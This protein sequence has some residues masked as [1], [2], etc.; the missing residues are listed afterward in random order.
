MTIQT[1]AAYYASEGGNYTRIMDTFHY[2]NSLTK[3]LDDF[4]GEFDQEVLNEIVLWKINRYAQVDADTI[5][6]I[7]TISRTGSDLDSPLTKD[8]LLRLI[9]THGVRLP[10]ASTILR[11]R[12]PC[13]YQIID[14]RAYRLLYGYTYPNTTRKDKNIDI[15]MK[16]LTDLRRASAE[17][18]IPF[19][20]MDRYLYQLDKIINSKH[21]LR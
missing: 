4:D 5:S 9:S 3:K 15:Y 1:L 20:D 6:L 8:I 19:E 10:M 7:N 14:Q 13:I 12:N 17:Y 16:Y 18:G 11:F 2:Q 21:S